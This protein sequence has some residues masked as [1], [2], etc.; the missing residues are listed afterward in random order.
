M[1][2]MV[3]REERRRVV[4]NAA[5]PC[6]P[7]RTFEGILH[8]STVLRR[9]RRQS[10]FDRGS[11]INF[12][13]R[14]EIDGLRHLHALRLIKLYGVHEVLARFA[15]EHFGHGGDLLVQTFRT[16][17]V[18]R[19]SSGRK[20]LPILLPLQILLDVTHQFSFLV[21]FWLSLLEILGVRE[22][23]HILGVA[24]IRQP[25]ILKDLGLWHLQLLRLLKMVKVF[26]ALPI[27]GPNR[28]VARILLLPSFPQLFAPLNYFIHLLALLKAISQG[29]LRANFVQFLF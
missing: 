24:E 28:S 26:D 6:S 15:M 5:G 4:V 27:Y 7:R 18:A 16:L 10:R 29:P 14:L 20:L 23:H 19:A 8:Q 11:H 12:L 1:A 21:I 25:V 2:L 9:F 22:G 3:R 17:K 13:M